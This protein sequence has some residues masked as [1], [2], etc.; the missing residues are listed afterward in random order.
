MFATKKL[1]LYIPIPE[2]KAHTYHKNYVMVHYGPNE[3]LCRPKGYENNKHNILFVFIYL[4][5]D[6]WGDK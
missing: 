6:R 5:T 1:F 3:N 4:F 2:Y